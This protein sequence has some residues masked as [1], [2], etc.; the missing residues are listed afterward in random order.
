MGVVL[1]SSFGNGSSGDMATVDV[2]DIKG[3]AVGKADLDDTLF[4]VDP[5][6]GAIYQAIRAFLTNK[7]QGTAATKTRAEVFLSKRK[8]YRQKG[9]GRARQGTI[10]APQFAGGGSVFGPVPRSYGSQL[11]KKVRG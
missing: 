2:F 6:E 5:S 1:R 7:R 9:T 11:P 3:K 4:G 8:L 10:R